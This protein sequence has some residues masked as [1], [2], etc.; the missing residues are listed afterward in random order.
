MKNQRFHMQIHNF[1]NF[2]VFNKNL[3]SFPLRRNTE[4]LARNERVEIKKNKRLHIRKA[5]AEDNGVYSCLARNEAGSSPITGT[6]PLSISS[7]DTA[8]IKVV[9]QSLIVKRGEPAVMHC[10]YE[11]ADS[12][13]W[14]FKSI[15]PLES[16][17]ERII[18]ENGTLV[19]RAAEHRDQGIYACHGRRDDTVQIY[20]AELQ[21]ACESAL[22]PWSDL[23]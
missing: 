1:F 23:F 4:S 6:F 12:V 21:L 11:D 18:Y 10:V 15:G 3:F 13:H 16:D 14:Y 17:D 5:S 19:I 7:N 20:T 8:T 9:P 2:F 22:S